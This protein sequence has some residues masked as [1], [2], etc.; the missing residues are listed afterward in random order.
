MKH[1]FFIIIFL[2]FICE[3][4]Y[5]GSYL[6]L[7]P[8]LSTKEDTIKIFG[9]PTETI[10]KNE[11]YTFTPTDKGL[12]FISIVFYK[13]TQ[14]IRNIEIYPQEKH[15][16][17]D[18]QEWLTLHEPFERSS[19]TEGNLIEYYLP[20]GV[21]LHYNGKRD[22][23]PVL[24]IE[25]FNPSRFE[26]IE[27]VKNKKPYVGIRLI[28]HDDAGYKVFEVEEKSPAAQAD[29]QKDDVILEIEGHYF[30]EKGLDPSSFMSALS[31]L[32][33][34]KKLSCVVERREKEKKLTLKIIEMDQEQ[35]QEDIQKALSL[36]Q[37]GQFLMNTGHFYEALEAFKKAIW[38]NPLEPLY[39]TSRGDV[40]Y[41]IGLHDFAID[42][43][44]KSVRMM[45]QH[46]PYYVL[47]VIYSEKKDYTKA[48]HAFQKSLA[49]NPNSDVRAQLAFCY[50]EKKLFR[51]AARECQK[52]LQINEDMPAVTYYLAVCFDKLHNVPKALYFYE[53]FLTFDTNDE[54]MKKNARERVAFF[55]GI[56]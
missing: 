18:Y 37:Q 54:D 51:D 52:V 11:R 44:T 55:G 47:G 38:L 43:L 12:K 48:I 13:D 6:G 50:F 45:P 4:G 39:Y 22:T 25:H 16:G 32:P 19:D 9:D 28:A 36:F 53:K 46:F 21:A 7:E 34:N 35:Q 2:T 14:V 40:Y 29:L 26:N 30:Y 41:R 1:I 42:E 33:I 17:S 23:A 49:L 24:F 3:V 27:V 20:H 5:T 31:L 10:V 8:G 56:T 15:Q